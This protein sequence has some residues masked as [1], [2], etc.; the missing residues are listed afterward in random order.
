[1][2]TN[3]QVLHWYNLLVG[4]VGIHG[5]RKLTEALVKGSLVR[6]KEYP[7]ESSPQ[8]KKGFSY[9]ARVRGK[10]RRE[11]E[12]KKEEAAATACGGVGV[13]GRWR[14]SLE[15]LRRRQGRGPPE[16]G[17]AGRA[18]GAGWVGTAR[19]A[20]CLRSLDPSLRRDPQEL[21]LV[22]LERILLD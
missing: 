16:G 7:T 22:G 1:M 10:G 8:A 6:Q 3:F 13:G 4:H 2:H 21:A 12:R 9:R 15:L 5:Q 17:G 14:A 11:R 20:L 18:E 19:T